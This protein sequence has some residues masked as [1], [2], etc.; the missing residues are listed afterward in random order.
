M[1]YMI[2]L[3]KLIHNNVLIVNR[4]KQDVINYVFPKSIT[5]PLYL[6]LPKFI[7]DEVDKWIINKNNVDIKLKLDNRKYTVFGAHVEKVIVVNKIG[8]LNGHRI[9]VR[10]INIMP[11]FKEN[12][13]A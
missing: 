10:Y 12:L 9:L 5:D 11:G 8:N 13:N 7:Y 2:C 4:S 3:H 6:D 1:A